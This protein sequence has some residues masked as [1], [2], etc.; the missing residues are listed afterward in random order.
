MKYQHSN[1]NNVYYDAVILYEICVCVKSLSTRRRNYTIHTSHTNV[2]IYTN[3]I[4][5]FSIIYCDLHMLLN[6]SFNQT[7][8]VILKYGTDMH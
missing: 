1:N 4:Y 8:P 3:K 5:I 2:I 6:N 7:H